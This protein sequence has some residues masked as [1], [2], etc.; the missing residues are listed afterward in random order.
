MPGLYLLLL[1][2]TWRW[3]TLPLQLQ[4]ALPHF[5]WN[6]NILVEINRSH[7]QLEDNNP[8]YM[9]E[10]CFK[11]VL[12][13]LEYSTEDPLAYV[14]GRGRHCREWSGPRSWGYWCRAGSY[15]GQLVVSLWKICRD[16]KRIRVALLQWI[17][18]SSMCNVTEKLWAR[19][20]QRTVGDV[21][22]DYLSKLT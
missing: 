22:Q 3:R 10:N 16:G 11:S 15:Q 5:L 21:V 14:G 9:E 2:I 4:H 6:Q 20:E 19:Y 8:L 1:N 18:N 7:Q 12:N 17:S 13:E